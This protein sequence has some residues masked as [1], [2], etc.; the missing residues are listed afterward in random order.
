MPNLRLV[1]AA[2]AIL[3][4]SGCAAQPPALC[5][6]PPDVP[7][8][9]SCHGLPASNLREHLPAGS[10]NAC[11]QPNWP[12]HSGFNPAPLSVVIG[13]GELLD[14]FGG[15]AGYDLSPRGAPYNQRSLPYECHGYPY[16]VY[17]VMKPLPVVIGTAAPAFGEPGGA[18]QVQTCEKVDQLL[19]DHV[20]LQVED[21][22]PL[23]CDAR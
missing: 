21:A 16:T 19:A 20:L 8:A 23:S 4:I 5:T 14:R 22:A 1:S 18:V 13:P 17:K 7:P 12:V 15:T 6:L 3:L 2:V 9:G 11:G 10:L